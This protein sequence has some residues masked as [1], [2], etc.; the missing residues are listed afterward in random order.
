M[1]DL[2]KIWGQAELRN[3]SLVV[4]WRTDVGKLGARVADYLNRELGGQSLGEIEP[5]SFFPLGGVSIEDDLIEFPES[6]LYACPKHDMI[7]FRGDPPAQEWLKYLNLILDVAG[8]FGQVKELYTI[9]GMIS[10][11]AHTTPRELLT[12][13]SSSQLKQ[14]LSQYSP[15]RNMNYETP[16]GHRPTLNS[17]LLWAARGRNIPGAALWVTIPFYLVTVEDLAAQRKILQFFDQRFSLQIE[18]QDIDKEI[19]RQNQ[20]IAQA[21]IESP[22]VNEYISKLESNL[23]LSEVESEK[24]TAEIGEFLSREE[25]Q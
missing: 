23:T 18:F 24:L 1:K 7:I 2:I 15:G 9:G 12:Y 8:H 5:A 3:P 16:P 19:T 17:F 14:E 25:S 20:R 13:F 11:S 10:L 6:K 21:R 22:E 4:C